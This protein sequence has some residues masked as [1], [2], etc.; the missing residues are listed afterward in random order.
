MAERLAKQNAKQ[1]PIRPPLNDHGGKHELRDWSCRAFQ[2]EI[3]SQRA[4]MHKAL[5]IVLLLSLLVLLSSCVPILDLTGEDEQFMM[6]QKDIKN[7]SDYRIKPDK[8]KKEY[9]YSRAVNKFGLYAMYGIRLINNQDNKIALRTKASKF[10][11]EEDITRLF[12][13][14]AKIKKLY[15]DSILNIDLAE[16]DCEDGYLIQ[17]DNFF[18]LELKREHILYSIEIEGPNQLKLE[19]IKDG[20]L[21]KMEELEKINIDKA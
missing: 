13:I 19:D 14:N 7:W 17:T 10:Y 4:N 3:V 20:L 8:N 18:Y 1:P 6:T 2:P 12:K 15:K 11:K 5:K 21:Q 16:Y 9:F